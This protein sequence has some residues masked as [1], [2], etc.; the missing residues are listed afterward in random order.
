MGWIF[1][2]VAAILFFFDGVGVTV[3]PKPLTWGL[4]CLALGLAIGGYWPTA[5]RKTP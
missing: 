5:W 3:I 1:L 2:V 4:F